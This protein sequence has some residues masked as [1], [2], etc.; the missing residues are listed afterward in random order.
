MLRLKAGVSL[1]GLTPQM[2]LATMVVESAITG[3]T[4]ED[5][6]ITSGNDG[7]HCRPCPDGAAQSKHDTGAALDFRTKHLGGRQ[8]AVRDDVVV[9]LGPEFDVVLES[10]GTPNEHLH[11][12]YDP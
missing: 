8:R 1:Q 11:V 10:M 9:A 4:G 2:V 7:D 5:T 6:I 3:H 12:E